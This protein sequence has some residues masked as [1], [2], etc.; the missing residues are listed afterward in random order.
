M[1]TSTE[2]IKKMS[3]AGTL[4]S[5]LGNTQDS[6]GDLV[7]QIFAQMNSGD[8]PAGNLPPAP[9]P[10]IANKVIQAAPN[11]NTIAMHSMD[12][13]P[14]QAHIIGN[15][16]PSPSDFAHMMGMPPAHMAPSYYPNQHQI[17]P[18]R[19]YY[20]Q[21]D[22]GGDIKQFIAKELKTPLMVALIVFVMTLPIINTL[23]AHYIPSLIR[24]GGDLTTTGNLLRALLGGALF[25]ILQ[26]IVV[27]LLL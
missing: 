27:P 26:R 12:S 16:Q 15:S 14:S 9:S 5:D 25:W 17:A 22:T 24:M 6:D 21:K 11:P 13:M 2:D 10:R 23:F 20:P 19:N 8:S 3:A 4:I 1:I 7:Q 18:P